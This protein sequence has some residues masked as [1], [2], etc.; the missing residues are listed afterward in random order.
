M[1]EK[2]LKRAFSQHKAYIFLNSINCS[3]LLFIKLE[4]WISRQFSSVFKEIK[5]NPTGAGS[6]SKFF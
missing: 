1:K 6:F 2:M 3:K 4:S 5:F